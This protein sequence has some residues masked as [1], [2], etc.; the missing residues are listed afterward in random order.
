[1]AQDRRGTPLHA[2]ADSLL[3]PNARIT[4][5][6]DL[7]VSIAAASAAAALA[8][9]YPMGYNESVAKHAPWMAP[10]ASVLV[11]VMDGSTGGTWGMT[12][13][14]FVI[15]NTVFA[16]N[17]SAAVV[18]EALRAGGYTATVDLTSAVYTITFDD[19]PEVKVIPSTLSGDV[20]QLT[21][22]TTPTATA[23]TGTST[24][25]THNIKGFVN[26]EVV[27]TGTETGTAVLVVLTGTDTLCT[28]TTTNAHNLVTGMSVTISGATE[29]NLNKTATIT[30]LTP[31][32]F[33]YAVTAVTGGTVDA[34]AYTTTNDIM[35][36][37]MVK[38][39][40]HAAVPEALVA[41]GD[42]TALRTALKN[43]LIA[44]DLIVQGLV[45]R[46]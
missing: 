13:N 19:E 45:G 4:S 34:G 42:V 36:I 37:I 28:A 6:R 17:V 18:T 25:G 24:F 9:G 32:T 22:G 21:G 29:S 27:Q 7:N 5:R 30:V 40:I 43:G 16:H 41:T 44:D 14:S 46:F 35:A 8:V 2:A 3:S 15:A 26:P 31:T 23:T 1:M 11:V 10:D 20:T 38:G 33:T 39:T 12:V